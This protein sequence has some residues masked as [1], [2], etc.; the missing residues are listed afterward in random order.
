[1]RAHS[2]QPDWKC[3][4]QARQE[5][6]TS[7]RHDARHRTGEFQG[8]ALSLVR[9][10]PCHILRHWIGSTRTVGT[11]SAL[12]V[13]YRFPRL[14]SGLDRGLPSGPPPATP[15]FDHHPPSLIEARMS[16]RSYGSS[17]TAEKPTGGLL[18]IK[19]SPE[20]AA[21]RAETGRELDKPKGG[22][23]I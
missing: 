12:S 18:I 3:V 1:V 13:P 7:G 21:S 8:C 11:A 15:Y 2:R 4:W 10:H 14:L 6:G 22:L 17:Q 5:P 9:P 16:E 23:V 20:L 19:K